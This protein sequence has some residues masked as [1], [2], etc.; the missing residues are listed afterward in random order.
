MFNESK[1]RTPSCPGKNDNLRVRNE[2]GSDCFCMR[3]WPVEKLGSLV[4]EDM[5]LQMK[6]IV[7][8]VLS[9]RVSF[10]KQFCFHVR[11]HS[12]S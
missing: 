12:K 11:I 1:I 6:N 3:H 8:L 9:I 7:D 4:A 2:P 5:I 10:K